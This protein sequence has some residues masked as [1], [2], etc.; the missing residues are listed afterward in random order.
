MQAIKTLPT[1]PKSPQKIKAIR[2]K[3]AQV[4]T[5]GRQLSPEYEERL[6]VLNL[7][8]E[9]EKQAHE[10]ENAYAE[11]QKAKEQLGELTKIKSDLKFYKNFC[12]WM[13]VLYLI[14]FIWEW[15]N[16]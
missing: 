4:K 16:K 15:R 13:I 2:E 6:E 1:P 12:I 5:L 14:R 3:A 11:L 10:K 7:V 9:D 8:I